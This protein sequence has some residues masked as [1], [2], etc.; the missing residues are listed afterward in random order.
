MK[1]YGIRNKKTGEIIELFDS[2]DKAQQQIDRNKEN[3]KGKK[4]S[5][6][7]YEVVKR[8]V[9]NI[10]KQFE[11]GKTYIVGTEIKWSACSERGK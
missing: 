1:N 9:N 5:T 4:K 6:A 3:D 7:E 8:T 11:D 2:E 10:Y